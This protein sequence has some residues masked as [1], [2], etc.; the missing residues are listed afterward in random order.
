MS[1]HD[2]WVLIA[3]NR[4]F[5]NAARVLGLAIIPWVIIVAATIDPTGMPHASTLE[6]VGAILLVFAPAIVF[7]AGLFFF[8]APWMGWFSRPRATLRLTPEG[9]RCEIPGRPATTIGPWGRISGMERRGVT[10]SLT[11]EDGTFILK[12]P[13]E[14]GWVRDPTDGATYTFAA[15]LGAYRPHQFTVGREVRG[16][17]LG[18][19]PRHPGD[20]PVV[21]PDRATRPTNPRQLAVIAIVFVAFWVIVDLIR[22]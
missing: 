14:L 12:V 13:G 2:A 11:S 15:A 21:M 17:P 1:Q 20:D 16:L 6:T 5:S 8:D 18:L 4:P 10:D 9:V 3:L 19:R 7:V 22:S